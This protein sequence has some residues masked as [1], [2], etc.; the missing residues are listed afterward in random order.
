MTIPR[1]VTKSA[2]VKS[3]VIRAPENTP[4]YVDSEI[5]KTPH[6]T[7]QD[8]AAQLA[9]LVPILAKAPSPAAQ[10]ETDR[11]VLTPA[12][13][14]AWQSIGADRSD[15]VSIGTNDLDTPSDLSPEFVNAD[16]FDQSPTKEVESRNTTSIDATTSHKD[17]LV[18]PPIPLEAIETL[19]VVTGDII[20]LLADKSRRTRERD[21]LVAVGTMRAVL[22]VEFEPHTDTWKTQQIASTEETAFEPPKAIQPSNAIVE[23]IPPRLCIVVPPRAAVVDS[24]WFDPPLFMANWLTIKVLSP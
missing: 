9:K 23:S 18:V 10:V 14:P 19:Q 15:F 6:G 1:A 2:A 4:T 11:V 7:P 3:P 8:L 24:E 21:L 22:E 16:H 13:P 20:K 12:L 5:V 17:L